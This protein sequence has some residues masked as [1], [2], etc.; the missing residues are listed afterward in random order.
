ML[1]RAQKNLA[2][3]AM[4][5]QRFFATAIPH[6]RMPS[7]KNY[8]KIL[9][10]ERTATP[11]MIKDAYRELA[12]THHPDV[13]GGAEPDADK[14]RDLMEAYGVLS[15]PES[16]ASYDITMKKN[17]DSF[18]EITENEYIKSYFPSKRDQAGNT[19]MTAASPA[20]GSYAETRLAEL[21]EQRKKYNVND[22]G[23]YRGGV[24][25]KDKGTIRGA[26]IGRPGEFHT[27]QVHNFYNNYHADSKLV[28]SEDAL[29]FKNFMAADKVDYNMS[30]PSRPMYY[31]RNFNFMKER[32]F[33]LRLFLLTL[34]G[35][36]G[37]QRIWVERDRMVR[38]E[39]IENLVNMPEHHFFSRG[40]VVT[41]KQFTGFEK[42]HK[43]ADDMA[44]W[45]KKSYP[46]L[47]RAKAE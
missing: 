25:Q 36:Y 46:T 47:F 35:M 8:Y 18:R 32:S 34:L 44:L 29:K 23:Y 1:Q 11:E 9:G 31:D 27:P 19:A 38:W 15:V 20:P 28:S 26:A 33:W 4:A 45:Y 6:S 16:R 10:V 13:V 7:E 37:I 41:K 5:Q 14:F 2:V 17:P 40:G 22:L 42:I 3:S 43:N 39:R 30:K 24:P 12:K 21:K